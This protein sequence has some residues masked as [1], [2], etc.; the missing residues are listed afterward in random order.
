ML[1]Q[2][3]LNYTRKT[4]PFSRMFL[5]LMKPYIS[6]K[7]DETHLEHLRNL[8]TCGFIDQVSIR[9]LRLPNGRYRAFFLVDG[10]KFFNDP[11]DFVDYMDAYEE[12]ARRGC[13]QNSLAISKISTYLSRIL[14]PS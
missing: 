5:L 2:F 3:P 10:M 6:R 12:A 4:E 7:R 14:R 9:H 13:L 11:I 8:S 1:E